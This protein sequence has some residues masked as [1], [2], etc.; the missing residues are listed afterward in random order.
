MRLQRT[1]VSNFSLANFSSGRDAFRSSQSVPE[2][3]LPS[4]NL[5]QLV[6]R[7]WPPVDPPEENLTEL[8]GHEEIQTQQSPL[9]HLHLCSS[10]TSNQLNSTAPLGTY[11]AQPF[12]I[13]FGKSTQQTHDTDQHF[14]NSTN[15]ILIATTS[16]NQT[17]QSAHLYRRPSQKLKLGQPGNLLPYLHK[18]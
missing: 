2:S 17:C 14:S 9:L 11:W 1:T 16:Y 5:E 8:R 4:G 13:A 12:S 7:L 18:I 3:T 10:Q 6:H 15:L